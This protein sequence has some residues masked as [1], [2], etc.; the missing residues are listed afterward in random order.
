M[1]FMFGWFGGLR[2]EAFTVFGCR[3][4]AEVRYILALRLML[5]LVL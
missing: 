4:N 1:G 2:G 3:V 5:G